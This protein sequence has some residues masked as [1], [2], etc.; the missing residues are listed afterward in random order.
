M[1]QMHALGHGRREPVS[2]LYVKDSKTSPMHVLGLGFGAAVGAWGFG[3]SGMLGAALGHGIKNAT[4]SGNHN[5]FAA[6]QSAQAAQGVLRRGT[7][8]GEHAMRQIKSVDRLINR[9]PAAMRPEIA[10]A[11]GTL[12][13]GNNARNIRRDTYHPVNI[14]IRTGGF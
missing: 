12:L 3:R 9:V 7:A 10:L 11:A 6:L 5:A 8:P 4:R 1:E 2:K 14:R 13:V